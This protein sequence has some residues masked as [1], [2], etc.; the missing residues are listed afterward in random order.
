MV[1]QKI[2]SVVKDVLDTSGRKKN[3]PKANINDLETFNEL[4]QGMVLLKNRKQ[5][6]DK[7]SNKTTLLENFDKHIL[8]KVDT[9]ELNYLNQIKTEYDL[10]LSEY[11]RQYQSFMENYAL[12][13]EA[14]KNC[15]ADCKNKYKS[16]TSAWSFK[17]RSCIVGC[18][19]KG[20]YISDRTDTVS[21]CSSVKG[22]CSCNNNG[23][24]SVT[25]GA[26]VEQKYIDGCAV[27]G[28]GSGGPPT[29]KVNGK[30][31]TNC[32]Q[33][34]EALGYKKGDGDYTK[35]ACYSAN[36]NDNDIGSNLLKQYTALTSANKELMNMAD[37]IFKKITKLSD[38]NKDINTDIN[39]GRYDLKN[40]L[41]DYE[42]IYSK[43]L[44]VKKKKNTTLNAQLEDIKYK[45]ESQSLRLVIWGCLAGLVVL[46]TIDQMKK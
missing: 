5:M 33:M 19:L 27:C 24:C 3:L 25:S 35:N 30:T 22:K 28:G 15:K 26:N 2:I 9:N 46:L 45:E 37:G 16:P 1:F 10:K 34:P 40:K 6:F 31:V 13:T 38:V 21:N 41:D 43:L 23:V 14:V 12:V 32:A 29:S 20:P 36:I 44:A 7:I 17:Q 11:G 4:Q 8:D 42:N 39:D 18:D